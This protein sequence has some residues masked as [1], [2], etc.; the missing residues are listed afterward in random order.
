MMINE[1][2]YFA[3]WTGGSECWI[4]SYYFVCACHCDIQLIN[5]NKF[6]EKKIITKL[7]RQAAGTGSRAEP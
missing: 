3:L 2:I 7:L 4:S 1:I 5:L 6:S